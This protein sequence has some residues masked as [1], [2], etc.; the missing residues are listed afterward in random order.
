MRSIL[1]QRPKIA[2]NLKSKIT[3]QDIVKHQHLQKNQKVLKGTPRYVFTLHS[4]YITDPI[5]VQVWPPSPPKPK[6]DPQSYPDPSSYSQ[7]TTSYQ[8]ARHHRPTPSSYYITNHNMIDSLLHLIHE[9]RDEKTT[10][11]PSV[12]V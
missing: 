8:F 4:T 12:K 1:S 10:N 5:N 6:K 9:Y 7:S 3:S 2:L 11:P